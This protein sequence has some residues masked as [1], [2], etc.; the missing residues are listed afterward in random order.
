MLNRKIVL[1]SFSLPIEK[2]TFEEILL[3]KNDLLGIN[4]ES[5]S[6]D[7]MGLEDIE[8]I[9]NFVA[10]FTDT[11]KNLEFKNLESSLHFSTIFEFFDS[12]NLSIKTISFKDCCMRYKK[13]LELRKI[14]TLKAITFEQCNEKSLKKVTISSKKINWMGFPA[15]FTGNLSNANCTRSIRKI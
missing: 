11:I 7:F 10:K 12:E 1:K 8:K 5:I 13:F 9:F 14:K 2:E 6:I 4:L 3:R 15:K